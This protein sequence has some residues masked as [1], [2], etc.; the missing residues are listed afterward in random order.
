MIVK[1][2]YC[3]Y[4]E[5]GNRQEPPLIFYWMERWARE[6][7]T[8]H[9]LTEVHVKADPRYEAMVEK[10]KTLPF[11]KGHEQFA[12]ANMKRWLA[13]SQIY[14]AVSDYDVFPTRPF[15]P[16]EFNGFVC[17]DGDGGPG[18]ITGKA[19]DFSGVADTILAY[20]EKPT[21]VWMGQ[22]NVS[23]MMMVRSQKSRYDSITCQISCYGVD[24]WKERPLVH[25][26]N[27]YLKPYDQ[28]S[29]VDQIRAIM[30]EVY[31]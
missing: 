6:G 5:L 17:F 4:H 25:F 18:F 10:A 8:P 29:R 26:G 15:P 27:G 14:G 7:W 24:G 1:D 12:P 11:L 19:R 22:R 16:A 20:T 23:E 13:F 9:V 21:D 30:N 3:C 2:I 31:P 28:I